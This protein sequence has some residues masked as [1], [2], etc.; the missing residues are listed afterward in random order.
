MLLFFKNLSIT[1]TICLSRA[2]PGQT[3][4]NPAWPKE[5]CV[6][7]AAVLQEHQHHLNNLFKP[8]SAWPSSA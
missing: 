2:Q 3:Q 1:Y 4:L 7:N 5:K 6:N 8:C